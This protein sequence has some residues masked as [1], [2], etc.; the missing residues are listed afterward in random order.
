[1]TK[2]FKATARERLDFGLDGTIPIARGEVYEL[3]SEHYEVQ[4]CVQ[5]GVLVEQ[6]L[7][8]LTKPTESQP[9]NDISTPLNLESVEDSRSINE[10]EGNDA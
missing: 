3:D 2:M 5:I 6:N 1:M 7:E 8:E 10:T 4:R 9:S